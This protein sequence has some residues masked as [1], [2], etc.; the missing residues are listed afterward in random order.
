[1]EEANYKLGRTKRGFD[2]RIPHYSALIAG[3]KLPIFPA[4]HDWSAGM[5][6]QLGMMLNDTLGDCTCAA[7]YHARQ[8]W[9]FNNGSMVTEPDGDVELLYERA[10]GYKPRQGGEGPGG[11]EQ[12]V[13]GY[14]LK[15]GAPVGPKGAAVDKISAFV[16]MDP[17]N[18]EDVKRGIFA[19]G[20]AYIGFNVPKYLVPQPG[21]T[22]PSVWTIEPRGDS[23]SVGGHAVILVGYD[24]EGAKLVSWGSY[25]RMTWDFFA[26]FVDEVYAI[27]DDEWF[28]GHAADPLGQTLPQLVAL[29]KALKEGR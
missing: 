9:S 4:A 2:A 29:M 8:V 24:A 19:C 21:G 28:K 10:C 23:T 20:L 16:E 11:N 7:V 12:K 15:K 5:P 6:G 18:L 13:L 17:R 3:Q 22:W 14:L 25:Y 27:A 26:A 1:M